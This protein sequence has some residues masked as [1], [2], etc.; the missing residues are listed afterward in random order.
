MPEIISMLNDLNLFDNKSSSE[1]ISLRSCQFSTTK[2]LLAISL[3]MGAMHVSVALSPAAQNKVHPL[4]LQSIAK[5]DTV[6]ETL[7]QLNA[8]ANPALLTPN[9]D[10]L[11]RR[12]AWV[13]MLQ[14]T[15]QNS[16]IALRVW[17]D[18]RQIEYQAF[19]IT[20]SIWL[21]S[22]AATLEALAERADVRALNPN[23]PYIN[24]LP[25]TQPNIATTA[26][27]A[28]MGTIEWGVSK[29]N[30]PSVWA[31]GITGQGVVIAGEDT[32]YRWD[33]NALKA[34][35]RGWDGTTV[36]H[37]YHWHDAIHTANA[38]CPAD[39]PVPCDDNGHGTHTLGTMLGDDGA[40][41]Q[42][43]VAPGARWI[44]CRNMNAGV[45]TVARYI[46]CMQW[47]MAPTDLANHNPQPDLAPDV[48][49]N[50]WGCVASEGCTTGQELVNAVNNLVT[51]GIFFVVAAGNDGAGCATIFNAPSI[52]DSS[53][54]V[55]STTSA[56]SVSN[57]SSRGPVSGAARILPD[58][59]APG[60]LVRSGYKTSVN[61]YTTLSGTSVA[62]PHV[63]GAAALLIATNP[64]LKGHPDQI[65]N[66]LRSTAM[67]INGSNQ[68][69]GGITASM[70]P[71][72][73]QG[74][75]RIDV[76]AAFKMAEKIFA[77]G[78]DSNAN[79]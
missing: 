78:F 49:S 28:I 42:I 20:N 41:N 57:F 12:R 53:F 3:W 26:S 74:S 21:R 16:Q 67:H 71:N 9:Q 69:C 66:L 33:H 27:L 35:Y 18:S 48:I 24:R 23:T 31:V 44:G 29:I 75:G 8:T 15:A 51:G 70:F 56:D 32:G 79:N 10:Y 73:V 5:H 39:S 17:L 1:N 46:E 55:A 54:V 38:S 58:V 2:I 52:Y 14:G 45:G 11:V 77:N 7:V 60:S 4:L 64:A 61:A 40:G 36:N 65:A 68:T 19:W 13:A 6:I 59:A 50:S 25:Q 63:A 37:N 22:D 72:P 30:A 62:A 47:M 34:K 43:G 76:Y